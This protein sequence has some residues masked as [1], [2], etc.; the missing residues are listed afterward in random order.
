MNP[1]LHAVFGSHLTLYALQ[2]FCP[3]LGRGARLAWIDAGNRFDAYGLAKAALAQGF[4]PRSVLAQIRLARPFNAFQLVTMLRTVIK[5]VRTPVVLDDP[6]ALFWD[7]E[8]PGEEAGRAFEDFLACLG[9]VPVPLLTLIPE[10]PAPPERKN[11]MPRFLDRA[12]S[13]LRLA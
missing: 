9:K 2:Q 7:S 12:R 13:V 11:F 3:H 1:A 5:E 8:L 10:R 6:L 4:D